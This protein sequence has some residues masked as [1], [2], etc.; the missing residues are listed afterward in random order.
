MFVTWPAFGHLNPTLKLARKLQRSGHHIYYLGLSDLETYVLSQGFEFVTVLDETPSID[1]LMQNTAFVWAETAGRRIIQALSRIQPDLLIV[2]ELLGDLTKITG[3]NGLPSVVVASTFSKK[4]IRLSDAESSDS[5]FESPVLVLCPAEFDF[6][7]PVGQRDR[8]YVEASIDLERREDRL[9]TWDKLDASKPLIYCSLGSHSNMYGWGQKLL[10]SV[11]EAIGHRP[12]LQLVLDA[13]TNFTVPNGV[14]VPENVLIA[15]WAPQIELL[16]KTS[17]TI[18]HGGLGTIK[19]CIYFG[20]PMIVFPMMWDQIDNAK[21]VVYH[22][23]GLSGDSEQATG[24]QINSFIDLLQSDTSFGARIST[25]SKV[26]RD[27][28]DAG[29]GVQMIEKELE[30]H[31]KPGRGFIS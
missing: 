23:L 14:R 15:Q 4:R 12:E 13:G 16:K 20:I 25:M 11:I 1:S 27:A 3:K 17:I 8:Y 9:F 26:F 18:T 28:E 10:L 30:R 5:A 29:K 21:R 31:S 19:E 2:D 24:Q 22:G 6:P 7:D